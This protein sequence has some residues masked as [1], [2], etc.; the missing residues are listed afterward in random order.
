MAKKDKRESRESVTKK[1]ARLS[2]HERET[3]KRIW[4]AVGAM[5]VLIAIIIA[6]ALAQAYW[7]QPNI[8]A[9]VVN[10]EK[11][12]QETMAHY[13]GYQQFL[14]RQQLIQTEQLEQQMD[15]KG[16]NGFFT[17]QIQQM[18][19]RLGAPETFS[20]Q[21]L[22]KLIDNLLIRQA[23]QRL[24]ITV[25]DAEVE[26]AIQ[27]AFGYN[28]NPPTPTPTPSP[29]P[30]ATPAA[31]QPTATP[32]PTPTPTATPLTYDGYQKRYKDYLSYLQTQTGITEQEFR[33]TFS[34]RLLQTKVEEAV[35][36]DVPK[37]EEAVHV[38]HILI[39]PKTPTPE[40]VGKGTPT[41]T[42]DAAVQEA[43]D[44]K[45]R[46]E[47]EDILKQLKG[48]ADF[49]ALAKKYSNDPGSAAKGGDLGW[50]GRNMMVKEFEDAAFALQKP[51]QISGIVKTK[52]GYH[53]IQLVEKDPKHP[54]PQADIK[55]AQDQAFQKWLD[56]Q[57]SK[58][59]ITRNFTMKMLPPKLQTPIP[60][61]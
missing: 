32:L 26:A 3:M 39:I 57:R 37:T 43:A 8:P 2:H 56:D 45:A 21:T 55:R 61:P 38:R 22:D 52:Y 35:T 4:I 47:A 44:K 11:I 48:G 18:K 9:A 7:I 27:Q 54:R 24:Q 58:A 10:G 31:G 23:A 25:S 1:Q 20:R 46:Q 60:L 30:T 33:Q 41:P 40:T 51:G 12:S 13:V 17:S 14:L 15:P 59:K 19:A 42:P 36:K 29:R 49:A 28:P 34:D 53:I 16:K 5:V 6:Y 50:F